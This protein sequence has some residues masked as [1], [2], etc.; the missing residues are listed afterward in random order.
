[1]WRLAPGIGWLAAL[2]GLALGLACA[3]CLVFPTQPLVPGSSMPSAGALTRG[4][5]GARFSPSA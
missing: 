2:A 4:A 5:A 1:M 3:G